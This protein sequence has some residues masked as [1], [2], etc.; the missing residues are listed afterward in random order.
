V[1][2]EALGDGPLFAAGEIVRGHE[3]HYSRTRYA[4]TAHAYAIEG[5]REGFLG[6]GAHASYVHVH[7]G[8]YPAA[9]ERFVAHARAFAGTR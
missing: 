4:R 7:L 1:E 3:F 5:E 9:A 6:A 8:A 2:A